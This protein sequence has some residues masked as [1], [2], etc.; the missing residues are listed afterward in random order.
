MRQLSLIR[1]GLTE[2]NSSGKFQGHTDIPLSAEGR[3]QA[4]TLAKYLKKTD[5]V[6][7]RVYSSPLARA[8]E[9]AAIVFPE[10]EVCADERLKELNFG[11][12]EGQTQAKNERHEA[13]VDWF[14]DPF[15]RQAPGGESY[16]ELRE[17]AVDWLESLP[18]LPHIVAVTHSGTIQMLVSHVLGVERPTWRKRIFLRHTGLTRFMFRGDEIIVERVND[19]HHL[20]EPFDPFTD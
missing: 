9:T 10:H 1:H 14:A 16:E 5:L 3:K 11:V 15:K 2:W 6:V 4:R 17:R 12:F 20:R 8:L 13:W 19:D 18:Q 7:D